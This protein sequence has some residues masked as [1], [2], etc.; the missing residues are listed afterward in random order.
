MHEVIGVA[1]GAVIGRRHHLAHEES[2]RSGRAGIREAVEIAAG[3]ICHNRQKPVEVCNNVGDCEGDECPSEELS[4]RGSFEKNRNRNLGAEEKER[5]GQENAQAEHRPNASREEL[6]R[7]EEAAAIAGL[8]KR[9]Q[10]RECFVRVKVS[11][12]RFH[13]LPRFQRRLVLLQLQLLESVRGV[14]GP[15]P[16]ARHGAHVSVLESE[17]ALPLANEL[18]VSFDQV[19]ICVFPELVVV[20]RVVLVVPCLGK[21]PVKPVTGACLDAVQTGGAE[22]EGVGAKPSDVTGAVVS[23]VAGVVRDHRPSGEP[24]QREAHRGHRVEWQAKRTLE[25]HGRDSDN[26]A[27]R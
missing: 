5:R 22:G 25:G 24:P 11:G 3:V 15:L 1:S 4:A 14:V 12:E 17:G 18:E 6:Q 27:R 21:H 10:N 19:R 20:E 26:T 13:V 23:P 9:P 2:G 8:G 7:A 16:D